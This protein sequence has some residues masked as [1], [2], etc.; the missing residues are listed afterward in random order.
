MKALLIE[1]EISVQHYIQKGLQEKNATVDVAGN[2]K[3]GLFLAST[4]QYDIMIID[5]ML[6]ELDGL[7]IIKTL[8]A[9]ENNTPIIILSA[10]GDVDD[11][12][13]GLQAGADDY[14]IKPFSFLEL[15]AR[16]EALIRRN[17]H[18]AISDVILTAQDL[19]LNLLSRTVTRAG[20]KL[21]LN[22]RE[23]KL[24]DFMLQHKGQVVTRTMLLESIWG[25]N[26]DPQTNVIDV[27]VSRLRAKI[28][29]DFA[30]PI[31]KTIRGS[32]YIVEEA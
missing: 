26:F 32:G 12:V 8:R 9:A 16:I 27:H 15:H 14:L 3:D 18:S 2:G 20:K 6:P 7:S 24:L 17:S 23:F 13:V 25:Y 11:R 29:K 19:E 30:T 4:E 22:D 28:D 10:L 1:D 21:L 5:R 31:I